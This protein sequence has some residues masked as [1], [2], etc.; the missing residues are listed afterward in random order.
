M[1]DLTQFDVGS[2]A[3]IARVVR[4]VERIVPRVRPLMFGAAVE[5]PRRDK[6]FRVATYDGPWGVG[7]TKTVTLKYQAA[8]PN[9]LTVTNLF[10]PIEAEGTRDCAVFNEGGTW[11]LGQWQWSVAPAFTAVQVTSQEIRF[12][13][14]NV[15]AFQTAPTSYATL[16]PSM[17]EVLWGA[18]LST[19][20]LTFSR[21]RIGVFFP[22]TATTVAITVTTCSTAAN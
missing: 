11:F 13:T 5:Q 17:E 2:A 4:A 14:I 9:T 18:S 7:E 20:S 19:A 21:R 3:R 15:A 6:P 10:L 16:V 1:A 22:G 12:S 8:T